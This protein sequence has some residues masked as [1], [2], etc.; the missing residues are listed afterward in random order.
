M[1]S[2]NDASTKS[3]CRDCSMPVE[4][5]PWR[6]AQRLGFRVRTCRRRMLSEE[7]SPYKD[8]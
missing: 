6:C 4:G 1:D 3:S 2:Q 7:A 5:I 8:A